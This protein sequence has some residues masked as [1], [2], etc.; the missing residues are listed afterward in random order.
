[1]TRV[2]VVCTDPGIPVGGTKGASIHLGELASALTRQGA[3]VRIAAVRIAA[4]P[5]VAV[6]RIPGPGRGAD[7][8]AR[9]AAE[10]VREDWLAEL[11]AAWHA[12]VTYERL[13][14]HSAAGGR[15][16]RRA[17]IPHVV[18]LNAPLPREAAT[19]RHLER[20]REA[21]RLE[22]EMLARADLVVPVSRPLADYAGLRGARRIEVLPNGVD[23]TR[24]P[25]R[26]ADPPPSVVF[27][28]GLRPWHGVEVIADA[29]R[30][31]GSGAPP[32]LVV[33]DGPGRPVLEAT[34]ADVVGEVPHG[35][36][37]VLLARAGIGVAPYGPGAPDYFSPLKVFEYLAA[38]LAVVAA[39]L[40]GV[41]DVIPAGAARLVPVGDPAALAAHVAELVAKPEAR[42]GLARRGRAGVAAAHTWDHRA[43]TL[44]DLVATLPRP[45]VYA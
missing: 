10:R 12:D 32:L 16:A 29:W 4:A 25:V 26:D 18:E 1:V 15:A 40:P 27:C 19:Y 39:A 33:G 11:A 28:G 41:V 36:V 6:A 42:R 38:G 13:A 14:L 23:I 21:V 17:G 31:L 37:P 43:R 2:L 35:Q 30:L 7:V 34:G 9:L 8:G 5:D 44:L 20:P 45:M 3:E 24:F 22:H